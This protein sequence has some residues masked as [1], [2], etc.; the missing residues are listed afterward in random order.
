VLHR[1][2]RFVTEVPRELMEIWS[3]DEEE[4]QLDMLETTETKFIN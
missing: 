2:S 1:P 3:V 4:P